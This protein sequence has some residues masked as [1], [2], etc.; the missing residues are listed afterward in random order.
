[1]AQ[2][3]QRFPNNQVHIPWAALC[4]SDNQ[5]YRWNARV[6]VNL[7][8]VRFFFFARSIYIL[9]KHVLILCFRLG[10]PFPRRQ[11]WP[12][13]WRAL[14]VPRRVIQ[15]GKKIEKMIELW[16]KNRTLEADLFAFDRDTHPY[17]LKLVGGKRLVRSIRSGDFF[18]IHTHIYFR[19]YAVFC[20]L[21]P[22]NSCMLNISGHF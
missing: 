14:G 19:R 2:N 7:W 21:L 1:M 13:I 9:E 12:R 17:D 11:F 5:I 3:F 15:W 10:G 16:P 4:S 22:A 20:I 8:T 18:V 6:Q